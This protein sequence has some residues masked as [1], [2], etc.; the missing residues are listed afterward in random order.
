M[1]SK[2]DN[3][4]KIMPGEISGTINAPS[5]KSMMQRTIAIA[6]L[7]KGK[8]KITNPSFCDDSLAAMEIVRALGANV[9]TKED[10]V[11]ICGIEN[12]PKSNILNCNESG[13][14]M[15][16]FS[17][18]AALFD[19]ELTLTG[20]GSLLSR[21]VTM[22]EKP[23]LEFGAKVKTNNG[24]PPVR[25][26]GPIKGGKVAVDGSVSSQFVSGL[27]IALPLCKND[28]EVQLINLKSK[29]YVS[30]T[31][32]VVSSFGGKISFANEMSAMKIE[33]NQ[34]YKCKDVSI[35]GDWSG[36]AFML[37][38]GAIAGDVR[39]NNLADSLQPDQAILNV[40]VRTWAKIRIDKDS[41]SVSKSEL[42]AFNFDATNS[43][44]LFPPLVA[45][46]CNCN[47]KSTIGGVERLVHKESNRATALV[48]EFTRIGAKIS[49]DGDKM[50]I[51][52]GKLKGGMVESH[53]DHRIAMACAIAA[54]NSENGV[55][56]RNSECV[57]KSYPDF[58]KDLERLRK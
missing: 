38:A 2:Q 52:G 27:V 51:E 46:A 17:P 15:R 54:L 9:D 13:L 8:S 11:T 4:V 24:K 22:I 40:L 33:G 45:L 23:L 56:V 26:K 14:C 49:I 18:I 44:D 19:R 29:D 25:V 48:D 28:S 37:V 5:S 1:N 35:E 6:A 39:V 31:E 50:E 20:R 30:M 47:G 57:S 55:E 16:M 10:N 43:P 3:S 42:Q 34:T 21:P 12:Q 36:S 58:F 53:G 7:A 41:V 32:S